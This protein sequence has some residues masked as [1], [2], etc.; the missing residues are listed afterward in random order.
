MSETL[1]ETIHPDAQREVDILTAESEIYPASEGVVQYANYPNYL[2]LRQQAL[3]DTLNFWDDQAKTFI[4]WFEPYE[5][6]LDDSN[7]PFFK[8]F[9]GGKVNIA[10]NALGRHVKTWRRNKLALIWVGEDGQ[11]RLYSYQGLWR[12]VNQFANVLRSM[13]V[14][15]GDTVTIYMGRV[16]ELPIAMLAVAKIG[17]IHS[18]VYGDFSEQ[19]LADRITGRPK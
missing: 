9:V 17:A 11:E 18:V 8:W 12:E 7:P 15:K 6:I 5:K 4:D 2:E 19:A 10:Y 16:P 13:G 1:Q 14:K 3:A